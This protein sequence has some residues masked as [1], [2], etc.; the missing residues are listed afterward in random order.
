MAGAPQTHRNFRLLPR[1]ILLRSAV[2]GLLMGL[3]F[4]LP[5]LLALRASGTDTLTLAEALG[6]KVAI[7][8]AHS[9]VI[10]PFVIWAALADVQ[11]SASVPRELS[12]A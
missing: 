11:R 12:P 7:T 8:L 10:V 5:L 4:G 3:V 1:G 6:T 9:L 2:V